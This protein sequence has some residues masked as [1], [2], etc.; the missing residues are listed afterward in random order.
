M[1]RSKEDFYD[2]L[3]EDLKN[4]DYAAA[5]LREALRSGDETDFLLALRAVVKARGSSEV[6]ASTGL[7]R[8]GIHKMLSARGNPRFDSLFK[9]LKAC[10]LTI[11]PIVGPKK[12]KRRMDTTNRSSM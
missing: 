3:Y 6:A 4:P 8:M 5:Y 7:S 2:R 10:D 11:Q 9:I 12:S 1:K